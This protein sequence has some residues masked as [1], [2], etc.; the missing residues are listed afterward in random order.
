MI[1]YRRALARDSETAKIAVHGSGMDKGI[2]GKYLI[3]N[4]IKEW[5]FHFISLPSLTSVIHHI[6]ILMIQIF[7]WN[8]SDILEFSHIAVDYRNVA[9]KSPEREREREKKFI[10]F[11][12][13]KFS[14]L[15][16][17]KCSLS[18]TH[19]S[20]A[21]CLVKSHLHKNNAQSNRY[22]KIDEQWI[23]VCVC[24]RL[25]LNVDIFSTT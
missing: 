12:I 11:R 20:H 6:Q 16:L 24:S 10:G 18:M 14:S 23:V 9:N 19:L 17:T 2:Y 15:S 5:S 25:V 21:S 22:L 1:S 3:F 4:V 8:E 13:G 7:D